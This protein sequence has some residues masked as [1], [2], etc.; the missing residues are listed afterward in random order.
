M[1]ISAYMGHWY[2]FEEQILQQLNEHHAAAAKFGT[3][4]PST[5][6]T[7]LLEAQ[8]EPESG[9]LGAYF[10]ARKRDRRA[11]ELWGLACD[12][13]EQSLHEFLKVKARVRNEGL[14]G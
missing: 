1:Q 10:E 11:R 2:R 7:R 9:G 5:T 4:I 8:G 12:R 3:G 6:A 14:A 13:H